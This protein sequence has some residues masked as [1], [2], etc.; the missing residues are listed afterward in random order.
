MKFAALLK[1]ELRQ[2]LSNFKTPKKHM[3]KSD[4]IQFLFSYPSSLYAMQKYFKNC[5][6]IWTDVSCIMS[7]NSQSKNVKL[8]KRTKKGYFTKYFW[9]HGCQKSFIFHSISISKTLGRKVSRWLTASAKILHSVHG[10]GWTQNVELLR[11][12]R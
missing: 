4:F 9:D 1:S 10:V 6:L 8:Q 11:H 2:L 3:A 7:K 12:P 5:T